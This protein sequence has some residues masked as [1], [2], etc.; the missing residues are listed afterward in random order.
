MSGMQNDKP[1]KK[2]HMDVVVKLEGRRHGVD[3][4]REGV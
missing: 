4:T 2:A 3:E 1:P